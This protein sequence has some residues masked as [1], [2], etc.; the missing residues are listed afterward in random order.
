MAAG[1]IV[2]TW[3]EGVPGRETKALEVFGAAIE[4]AAGYEKEGRIHGH[5][6]YVSTSR[7]A[8]MMLMDGE[9]EQLQKIRTEREFRLLTAKA[10]NIVQDF[11]IEMM[12]GGTDEA[13][14]DSVGLLLEAEQA[15]GL[16]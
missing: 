1:A 7:S 5:R 8:G 13:V 3:G 4:M 2:I 11:R 12:Q 6:E 9:W 15:L 16:I 14:Q 10:V